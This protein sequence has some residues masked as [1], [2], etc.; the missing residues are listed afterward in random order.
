M[1][2]DRLI[3]RRCEFV[4]RVARRE[5]GTVGSIKDEITIEEKYYYA[6]LFIDIDLYSL[7]KEHITWD[8]FNDEPY[9]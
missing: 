4:R 9:I 2:D 6:C 3:R 1:I 7:H 5:L 8:I